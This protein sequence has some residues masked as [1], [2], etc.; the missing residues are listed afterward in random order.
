MVTILMWVC[1]II[2]V[3]SLLGSILDEKP[4]S[5]HDAKDKFYKEKYGE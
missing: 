5:W 4:Q 1:G 2:I 3:L